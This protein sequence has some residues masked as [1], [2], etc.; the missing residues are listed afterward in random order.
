MTVDAF[1]Q[2]GEHVTVGAACTSATNSVD[3]SV[4][5]GAAS[6]DERGR[7]TGGLRR[8]RRPEDRRRRRSTSSSPSALARRSAGRGIGRRDR[9]RRL[10]VGVNR[11]MI[12]RIDVSSAN[13]PARGRPCDMK[14][15]AAAVSG[16]MINPS[17]RHRDDELDQREAVH[18][19]CSARRKH[20]ALRR[21]SASRR[22]LHDHRGAIERA[23]AGV[24]EQRQF[25]AA[26][27]GRRAR[28]RERRRR[29]V[30]VPV[31]D[32]LML[33]S[34]ASGRAAAVPGAPTV[35]PSG[36]LVDGI[37]DVATAAYGVLPAVHAS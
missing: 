3:T 26:E 12:D 35:M 15:V 20:G 19:A 14:K 29:Q 28:R 27:I 6:P 18:R 8:P 37:A 22:A 23:V 4:V 16:P 36:R 24:N 32:R 33:S 13:W 17:D 11:E 25:L 7:R 5:P 9:L 10:R 34:N 31:G 2:F 30:T 1:A 21:G